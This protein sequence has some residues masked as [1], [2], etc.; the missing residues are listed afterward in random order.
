MTTDPVSSQ[1]IPERRLLY[2]TANA[3]FVVAD[4]P[5]SAFA[6][7]PGSGSRLRR[8]IQRPLSMMILIPGL[9]LVA[10]GVLLALNRLSLH[11]ENA[12]NWRDRVSADSLTVANTSARTLEQAPGLLSALRQVAHDRAQMPEDLRQVME[13]LLCSRA[14]VASLSVVDAAGAGV[15]AVRDHLHGTVSWR[16]YAPSRVA[17]STSSEVAASITIMI[18]AL[19]RFLNTVTDDQP[20]W[21]TPYSVASASASEATQGIACA[22][23]V[24]FVGGRS[25]FAV[26]EFDGQSLTPILKSAVANADDSMPF[27]FS[28]DGRMLIQRPPPTSLSESVDAGPRS[29]QDVLA[30]LPSAGGVHFFDH[31]REGLPVLAAVRR[32]NLIDGPVLYASAVAPYV[33]LG[34]STQRLLSHSF[35]VE[36]AA[37]LSAT[38]VAWVIMRLVSHQRRQVL[39]AR[40]SARATQEKLD[41]FGSYRLIR[42]LGAGGMGEIWQAEH[43]LLARPAA[44]KLISM[45]GAGS[46]ERERDL[47]RQRFAKEARVTA[48]LCSPHTVTVYDFGFTDD[49]SFFYAM[50]LLDGLDLER[51][52]ATHGPQHPA[53]VIAI[54][55]QVCRSLA[56]AHDHGLIHRDIKPANIYLCRLGTEVDIAKVLD[57]GLVT[58]R[59]SAALP[60]NSR[61]VHGT[62][63]FIAPEQAQGHVTDGRADLYALGAVAYWLLSGRTLFADEDPFVLLGRQ[64]SDTPAPLRSVTQQRIPPELEALIFR[65]LAKDPSDR[66]RDAHALITELER[67]PPFDDGWP[68]GRAKAWWT[69]HLPSSASAPAVVDPLRT[70]T[71]RVVRPESLPLSPPHVESITMEIGTL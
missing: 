13:T 63:A 47:T 27:I 40:A 8:L 26:V 46:T 7:E 42:R 58:D 57:F 31:T 54:L 33:A 37:V 44:L 29:F 50:E 69:T 6:E 62:P 12:Q 18:P 41:A 34:A 45:E 71:I 10:G 22:Q 21:S 38:G 43:H 30:R 51:L 61:T 15:R 68:R 60:G 3:G 9:M 48:S 5:S 17:A 39:D 19:W 32:I 65:L 49:G 59:A 20:R 36:I 4:K 70:A 67:I 52:V 1:A 24:T 11:A 14:G 55:I 35:W 66:P 23:A 53:R 16:H 28:P 25:G 64:V 2:R 56:E